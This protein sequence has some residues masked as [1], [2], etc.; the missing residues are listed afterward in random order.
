MALK[1]QGKIQKVGVPMLEEERE[2]G[3]KPTQ[4][5]HSV[6]LNTFLSLVIASKHTSSQEEFKA[7][8]K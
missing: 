2:K 8:L 7:Q 4:R 5:F 1:S 3:A 6:K